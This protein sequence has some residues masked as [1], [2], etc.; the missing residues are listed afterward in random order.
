MENQVHSHVIIDTKQNK[1]NPS[2]NRLSRFQPKAIPDYNP[3]DSSAHKAPQH[4]PSLSPHMAMLSTPPLGE[5]VDWRFLID[6]E[7][8]DITAWK[9]SLLFHG[10]VFICPRI[11]R[12]WT[13]LNV[14]HNRNTHDWRNQPGISRLSQDSGHPSN[15]QVNVH[16]KNY[17]PYLKPPP[18][19][20][21]ST[22]HGNNPCGT[23]GECTL[24]DSVLVGHTMWDS[25]GGHQDNGGTPMM[26]PATPSRSDTCIWGSGPQNT[27]PF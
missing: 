24:E 12:V 25:H 11:C 8:H 15:Q 26:K 4:T 27:P 19:V 2:G 13:C 9:R 20:S 21:A 1:R 23:C 14:C 17:Y 10:P 7:V 16:R 5:N 18:V 22:S 6:T 3:A